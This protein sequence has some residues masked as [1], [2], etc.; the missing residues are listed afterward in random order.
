MQLAITFT[1]N[2]G[3]KITE[4]REYFWNSGDQK[5]NDMERARYDSFIEFNNPGNPLHCEEHNTV[6]RIKMVNIR[7]ISFDARTEIV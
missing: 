3:H 6:E 7:V 1:L 4:H 2:C 5:Q